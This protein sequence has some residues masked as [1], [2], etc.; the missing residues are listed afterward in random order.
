MIVDLLD[1]FLLLQPLF[2]LAFFFPL[3]M[4]FFDFYDFLD[5]LETLDIT[6]LLFDF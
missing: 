1:L 3:L 4:D 5:F 6:D 2:W